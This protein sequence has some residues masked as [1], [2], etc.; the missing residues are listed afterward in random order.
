MKITRLFDKSASIAIGID[1]NK[2]VDSIGGFGLVLRL[3]IFCSSPK[4]VRICLNLV[5]TSIKASQ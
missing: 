2:V 5:D 1:A 4:I 3:Q